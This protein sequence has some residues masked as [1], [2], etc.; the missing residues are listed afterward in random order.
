MLAFECANPL[1]GRTLNPH[2]PAYTCGG[3]SGGEGA[4]LAADGSALGLGSDIGGSV[5]IPASY[6][7]VFGLKP[8]HGRV[9]YGG[10]LCESLAFLAMRKGADARSASA[11]GFEALHSVAG[12]MGRSVADLVLAARVLFGAP[13][14]QRD[15]APLP[16]REVELPKKLKLGYYVDGESLHRSFVGRSADRA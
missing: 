8:G 1:W 15:V 7:G 14:A 12:P 6:C 9:P 11:G 2:A 10:A 3:S 5:R 4:L 13:D 16:F